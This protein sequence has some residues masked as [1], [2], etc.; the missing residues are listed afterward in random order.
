M[1][2]SPPTC[3]HLCNTPIPL[4]ELREGQ[5]IERKVFAS[6]GFF[7]LSLLKIDVISEVDV[8]DV[9]LKNY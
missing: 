3:L 2:A 1:R 6:D 4:R 7:F 8:E 5:K 9:C